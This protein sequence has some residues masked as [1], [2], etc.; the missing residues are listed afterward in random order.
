MLLSTPYYR[1][2][3]NID[4][5]A[6][7][8]VIDP[9]FNYTPY[10]I[11]CI[12]TRLYPRV[13]KL[14]NREV[15]LVFKSVLEDNRMNL[16][17]E[18]NTDSQEYNLQNELNEILTV[19]KDYCLID[20]NELYISSRKQYPRG[21]FDIM[22]DHVD[23][24]IDF[25]SKPEGIY[26][27]LSGDYK[28]KYYQITKN[29]LDTIESLYKKGVVYGASEI[30]DNWKLTRITLYSKLVSQT[31]ENLYIP[32]WSDK[33]FAPNLVDFLNGKIQGD[34]YIRIKVSDNMVKRHYIAA[35]LNKNNI[36]MRYE[37]S[38]VIIPVNNLE[39]AQYISSLVRSSEYKAR[40]KAVTRKVGSVEKLDQYLNISP[41]F[42]NDL[43]KGS[44]LDKN[45][46]GYQTDGNTFVFSHIIDIN[47]SITSFNEYLDTLT[48][49]NQSKK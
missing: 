19:D 23:L 7:Y 44:D 12:E 34:P 5:N 2:L 47:T 39:E 28:Y 11:F 25:I 8:S 22:V 33:R 20:K 18:I 17:I 13:Y 38:Y 9:E 32:T 30:A 4:P 6:D 36:L 24:D 40:G 10:N 29:I 3:V 35:E 27:K 14:L 1:S 31:N 41:D 48:F 37:G 42:N 21:W 15:S 46:T 16:K 26:L 43:D 49:D 45:S